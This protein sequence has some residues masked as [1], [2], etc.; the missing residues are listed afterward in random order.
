MEG[1]L[2]LLAHTI[3]TATA[4]PYLSHNCNLHCSL[5]QHGIFNPLSEARD[6]TASSSSWMLVGF[7]FFFFFAFQGHTHGM[8][9]FPS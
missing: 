7:F 1:E 8:W 6:G 9:R 2:Q 3:A 5:R 4:T